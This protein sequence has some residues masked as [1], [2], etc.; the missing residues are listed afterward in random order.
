M[1]P[2]LR[3]LQLTQV[4]AGARA[5]NSP[6][7]VA[8]DDSDSGDL[9]DVRLLDAYETMEGVE[10]GMKRI[11]V[12]VSGMTCA[13]CS[14]SVEEA[15][16]SVNGVLTASVALLQ[17]KADV[18]FDPRLVKVGKTCRVLLVIFLIEFNSTLNCGFIGFGRMYGELGVG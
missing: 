17:N 14:N 8:G 2:S 7:N 11:Q 6:A 12:G 4:V 1:A 5:R 3:D 16:R 18:V 9:E 15:L 13:A 10:Q